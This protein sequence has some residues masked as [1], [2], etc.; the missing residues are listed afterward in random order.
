MAR[1]VPAQGHSTLSARAGRTTRSGSY[2]LGH[3]HLLGP[4]GQAGAAAPG[5]GHPWPGAELSYLCLS[6]SFRLYLSTLWPVPAPPQPAP[7]LCGAFMS[8]H[9]PPE[10]GGRTKDG[11]VWV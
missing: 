7:V 5:Q 4:L 2:E 1:E 3:F 6:V 11:G 8:L 10:G 9:W